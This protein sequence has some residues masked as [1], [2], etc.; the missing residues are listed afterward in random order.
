MSRKI[1]IE[2]EV[3]YCVNDDGS[4]TNIAVINLDKVDIRLIDKESWYSELEE[5][6]AELNRVKDNYYNLLNLVSETNK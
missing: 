3:I 2:G 1:G 6:V 5:K 4:V